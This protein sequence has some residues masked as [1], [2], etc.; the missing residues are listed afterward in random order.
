MAAVKEAY[1]SPHACKHVQNSR[2][3]EIQLEILFEIQ[4][5]VGPFFDLPGP[6]HG[7]FSPIFRHV[8][9]LFLITA[10]F[11]SKIRDHRSF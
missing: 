11:S 3:P 4:R 2:G 7:R 9:T 1:A 8:Q 10:L 5:H 6:A